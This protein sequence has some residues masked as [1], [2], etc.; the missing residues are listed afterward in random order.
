LSYFPT[1]GGYWVHPLNS[2]RLKVKRANIHINALKRSVERL[3]DPKHTI[4]EKPIMQGMAKLVD[5]DIDPSLRAENW[6]L[7]IGDIVTNLRASLDHIAW[8]LAMLHIRETG[9]RKLTPSQSRLV[10]FP[11]Y[12]EPDDFM[13]KSRGG[14][15][16]KFVLP[17]ARSEI[18]RFQPYNRRNWPELKLLGDLK[19]LSNADKHR[20]VTPTNVRAKISL[21]PEDP[22][23]IAI[24]NKQRNT[25]F[26]ADIGTDLEPNI[27]YTI[28]VY[29]RDA[30]H[31][32]S[33]NELP[34]I[35]NFIRDEVIPSFTS[36]F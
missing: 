22:G 2:A 18:E 15:A 31:P 4:G 30:L 21:T 10:Q 14:R 7:I 26:I 33:I 1:R 25:K 16:L 24:L 35:H 12:D 29:P 8:E 28:A 20:L 19:L 17:R 11:L 9:G 23:I 3:F 13:A 6:G 32:L 27:T 5:V 34:L 36:F